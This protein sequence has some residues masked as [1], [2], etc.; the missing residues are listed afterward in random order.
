MDSHSKR[1]ELITKKKNNMPEFITDDYEN[2][3]FILFL[4]MIGNHFDI[5]HTYIKGMTEQRLISE[6]NSYG[7]NDELLYNYLQNYLI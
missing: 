5:I 1:N 4:D 3:E 6:N 2:N 7:I